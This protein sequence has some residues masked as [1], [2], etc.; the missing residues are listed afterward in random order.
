[1]KHANRLVLQQKSFMHME[2]GKNSFGQRRVTKPIIL[3]LGPVLEIRQ[4][5]V[6]PGEFNHQHLTLSNFA[7]PGNSPKQ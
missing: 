1:M 7:G 2:I 5:P 6:G 3:E 4:L